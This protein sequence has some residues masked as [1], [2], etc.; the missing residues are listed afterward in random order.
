MKKLKIFDVLA[1]VTVIV[2][3]I[4]AILLNLNR[5]WQFESGYYDLGIF[6]T[7]IWKVAHFQ[8]PIIDHLVV[9]GKHIFADHFHPSI[10]LFSPIYWFTSKTE[11]LLIAQD[12]VV[13][14]S[15]LILYLIGKKLLKNGFLSFSILIAY[16]LF[17]GLQNAVMFDFHEVTVMTLFLM[18]TYWSIFNNKKMSYFFFLMI[19]LGFKE[20]LFALGI[21]ISIFIF[22]Y[23][24]E[25]R[26]IALI[27]FFIS[28][29]WGLIAIKIIIPF[30]SGGIYLYSLD[31]KNLFELFQRLFTPFI[32]IKTV[33]LSLLSFGFLPILS[34]KLFPLIFLH[35]GIRF[36]NPA[37]E[38]W[39]LGLHYNAEIAPTLA[40]ASLMGLGFIKKY[41]KKLAFIT[42][43]LTIIISI[44]LHRFVLRGPFG[45]TYN[46]A[47]Y[48]HTANF[49]FLREMIAVVPKNA[50][51]TAQNNLAGYFSHQEVYI[52]RPFFKQ[53]ETDYVLFDLRPGQ[54]PNN[55]FMSEETMKKTFEIVKNH[56][57]YQLIYHKGDQYVFKKVDE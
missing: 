11:A 29:L 39:D 21:G 49:N 38:R 19:T 30:F 52:L 27:S 31:T 57:K 55:L 44:I 25:W 4:L 10:F 7:A 3:S 23:K 34:P 2:F 33:F 32:K 53:K 13:G 14:L 42:A 40:I 16:F 17:Q 22:F 28:L 18:L 24:K 15:G 47:F 35:Y 6:D 37:G 1:F 56:P 50:S 12:I 36:I 20:S 41:S 8:T 26:K 46:P 51:V 43:I 48:K 45:L 9:G 5:Y 54:N